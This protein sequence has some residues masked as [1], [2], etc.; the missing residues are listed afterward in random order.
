MSVSNLL[1]NYKFVKHMLSL[2]YEYFFKYTPILY[3]H[4]RGWLRNYEICIIEMCSALKTTY[5]WY[6]DGILTKL[7]A[8]K[9]CLSGSKILF[10][11][12]KSSMAKIFI[13]FPDIL[14][15]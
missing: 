7:V 13:G 1:T 12:L 10:S 14:S 8:M 3:N 2:G 11:I 5:V 4:I 15:F 6:S 9:I